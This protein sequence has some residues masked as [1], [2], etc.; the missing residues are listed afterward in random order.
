MPRITIIVHLITM[1]WLIVNGV[2]H[3]AQV[4]WKARAGTLKH[5]NADL[6]GLLAIGAGL[7]LAG[8]AYA[9]GLGGLL[10][11]EPPSL[12]GAAGAVVVLAAVVAWMARRYGFTFL[13]GTIVLGV[14]HAAVLTWTAFKR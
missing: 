10:R 11:K 13:T 6:E 3:T 2:A 1:S 8:A 4:L 14:L 5:A 7:L 9:F 12:A